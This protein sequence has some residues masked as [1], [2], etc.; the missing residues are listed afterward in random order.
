ML[1]LF[2][3]KQKIGKLDDISIGF[4][5]DLKYGRTVHSLVEAIS[6]YNPKII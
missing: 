6:L 3:I 4:F 5:G 2:T 1:D